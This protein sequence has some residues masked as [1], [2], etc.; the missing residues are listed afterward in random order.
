MNE[1]VLWLITLGVAG[2]MLGAGTLKLLFTPE[3][4]AKNGPPIIGRT[5]FTDL[6]WSLDVPPGLVK[7]IGAAEVLGGLGLVLPAL[8][9]VATVLVPIAAVGVAVTMVGAVG[10]H[11]HR[12]EAWGVVFPA[13]L[14]IGAVLVAWSRFAPNP[15]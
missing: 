1:T 5:V 10:L 8:T 14:L 2:T 3:H 6:N 9:G 7:F 11:I 4:L 15:L 13:V 12:R